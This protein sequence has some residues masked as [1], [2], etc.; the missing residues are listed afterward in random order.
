MGRRKPAKR[1]FNPDPKVTKPGSEWDAIIDAVEKEYGP[2][3]E[4]EVNEYGFEP[5]SLASTPQPWGAN[6][7]RHYDLGNAVAAER[8]MAGDVM[9]QPVTEQDLVQR[10]IDLVQVDGEAGIE[11]RRQQ[12]LA[13]MFAI[14]DA[15]DDQFVARERA[16]YARQLER[17]GGEVLRQLRGEATRIPG[18]TIPPRYQ[19]NDYRSLAPDAGDIMEARMRNPGVSNGGALGG[20]GI[21]DPGYRAPAY[22]PPISTSVP[23]AV[24]AAPEPSFLDKAWMGTQDAWN[25]TTG[26]IRDRDN[27]VQGAAR[28]AWGERDGK[29][30]NDDDWRKAWAEKVHMANSGDL[31]SVIGSR[32]LQ[33]GALTGAGALL[34][35]L[36]TDYEDEYG[37]AADRP[38][39]TELPPD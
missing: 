4:T 30:D 13:D 1:K 24:S 18:V 20:L 11:A 9:D 34:Y 23:S 16:D 7:H 19:G 6:P 33:A 26:W 10:A 28:Y 35:D 25:N 3:G 2:S 5:S 15:A 36:A 32:A 37:G 21:V 39:S 14:N 29:W 17:E 22:A 8:R 27:D 12:A 31:T 38:S